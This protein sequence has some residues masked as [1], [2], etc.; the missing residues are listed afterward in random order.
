VIELV[1]GSDER[2]HLHHRQMHRNFNSQSL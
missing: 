2:N 1:I